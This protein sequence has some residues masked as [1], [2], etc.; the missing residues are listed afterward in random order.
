[1]RLSI[2]NCALGDFSVTLGNRLIAFG[3]DLIAANES[4]DILFCAAISASKSKPG[5][6]AF[7]KRD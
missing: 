7:A 4:V 5:S 1:M 6:L 3:D 2:L